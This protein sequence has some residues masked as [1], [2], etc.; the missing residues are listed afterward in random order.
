MIRTPDS[1]YG[2]IRTDGR[3]DPCH[4]V[5]VFT[6]YSGQCTRP[7]G[8]CQPLMGSGRSVRVSRLFLCP[9]YTRS[10][11]GPMNQFWRVSENVGL[12]D[13]K[14]ANKQGYYNCSY[15]L[16][17]RTTK[18]G[19]TSDIKVGMVKLLIVPRSSWTKRTIIHEYIVQSETLKI[20]LIIM[21]MIWNFVWYSWPLTSMFG[22]ALGTIEKIRLELGLHPKF[23]MIS[24]MSMILTQQTSQIGL[25]N[26]FSRT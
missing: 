14:R 26:S 19:G 18:Y 12:I 24:S 8:T 23:S 4:P 3:T 22:L 6:L 2:R 20:F 25:R 10:V 9:L 5:F 11:W 7:A 15:F 13:K 17:F 21:W 16:T 1:N